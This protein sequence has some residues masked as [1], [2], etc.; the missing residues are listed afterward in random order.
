M[1]ANFPFKNEIEGTNSCFGERNARATLLP[2]F[3]VTQ[4]SCLQWTKVLNNFKH[5]N[6]I[7][8]DV[9]PFFLS[10]DNPLSSKF[11]EES[12]LNDLDNEGTPEYRAENW[13]DKGNS[14]F[15]K[16]KTK[17]KEALDCYSKAIQQKTD[18]K[19]ANSIY[20]SNRAAVHLAL[21]IICT[22]S[23][24]IS[25]KENYGHTIEDC[26]EAIK[27]NDKN[28]KAYYRAARASFML[29]KYQ[30][31]LTFCNLGLQVN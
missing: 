23:L 14:L 10:N 9:H 26:K 31:S 28:I 21:G 7:L 6:I 16:G 4:T 29:E 20:Y 27:L 15:S 5:N 17:Y 1:C 11:V 12:G 13:K 24:L 18:D 19:L 22:F 25:T 2:F 3:F 8:L 30:Q